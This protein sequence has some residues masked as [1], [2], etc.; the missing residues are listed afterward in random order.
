VVI[1]WPLHEQI[2]EELVNS[3][4]SRNDTALV[5]VVISFTLVSPLGDM[6][7]SNYS[8]CCRCIHSLTPSDIQAATIAISIY[9]I[10]VVNYILT[11]VITAFGETG[12][13]P[14]TLFD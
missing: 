3:D 2:L 12:F 13:L 4:S 10:T 9:L 14:Q 1:I 8:R 7:A 11:K 6:Q 5:V